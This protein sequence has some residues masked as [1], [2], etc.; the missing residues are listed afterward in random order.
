MKKIIYISILFILF[1]SPVYA[2]TT[3]YDREDYDNYGVNKKWE[4]TDDNIDNIKN[5]PLVNSEEKI[6][7][8]AEILTDSE[9]DELY[10]EIESFIDK[11][12]MEMVIVTIDMAYSYDYAN[13]EYAA[14]FYDY[15][16]FG[17]DYKNYD[18][19]LL[20]R[21]TYNQDPYYNMYMFGNA[22]LYFDRVRTD[23]I[24]DAIYSDLHNANYLEGF[25]SFINECSYYMTIGKASSYKYY[26]IDDYG[27]LQKKF[28]VS[29]IIVIIIAG[30]AT[31]VFDLVFINKN[32]MIRK[33][34]VANTYLDNN[35]LKFTRSENI[36]VNKTVTHHHISSSSSGGSGGFSGGGSHSGSSGGGH[37]SG[38]G[39]HG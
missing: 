37:S 27:Y 19:I 39:R 31:L 36:F 5:T 4:I 38:G 10:K 30:I 29:F 12:D 33:A 23:D 15:N 6:Y 35:S 17:I 11:Y 2:S 16:N 3:T 14:D 13:E 8:F 32:K 28:H 20:L 22:Q 24:L 25:T 34:I 1:I 7:D 21:N 26:Y 9:E 18:G